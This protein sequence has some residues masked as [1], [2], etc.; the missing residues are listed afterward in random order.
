MSNRYAVC[1]SVALL[2][3]L[4]WLCLNV[5]R[6]TAQDA[7]PIAGKPTAKLMPVEDDMHEFME[8]AFEPY[9]HELK[10][11][12]AE[13]PANG[14]AWK[15][16]KASSLVLAEN[17]NLL[18]IRGPEDDRTAWDRIAVE[19]RDQGQLLYRAAKKRDYDEARKQYVAFVAK[20]NECHHQ[21]ADGEHL[22]KP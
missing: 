6:T 11:A 1:L 13:P 15:P 8:Y 12:L 21:F 9:F 17:G 19:L 16:V 7:E 14:K 20:C 10:E 3:G 2:V 18:M 5:S 4:A 22:Q